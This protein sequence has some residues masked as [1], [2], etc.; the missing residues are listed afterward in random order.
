MQ[1]PT[2][3]IFESDNKLDDFIHKYECGKAL[4]NPKQHYESYKFLISKLKDNG[5][6][7]SNKRRLM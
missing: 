4:C 1:F 5:N 6:N 7:K 2:V 3:F